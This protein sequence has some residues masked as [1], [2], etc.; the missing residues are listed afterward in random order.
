MFKKFTIVLLFFS[1]YSSA[2]T[3]EMY[4]YG[5]LDVVKLKLWHKGIK[6]KTERNIKEL[7]SQA[8][9]VEILLPLQELED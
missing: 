2:K 9:P 6:A 7:S 4:L 1:L 8:L 3:T 5:T